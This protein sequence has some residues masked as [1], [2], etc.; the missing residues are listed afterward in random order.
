MFAKPKKKS[1]NHFREQL[2]DFQKKRK[3]IDLLNSETHQSIDKNALN[4]N[5]FPNTKATMQKRMH[6]NTKMTIH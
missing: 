4:F 6:N 2:S 3:K 1:L 5:A